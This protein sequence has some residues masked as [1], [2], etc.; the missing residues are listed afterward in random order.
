MNNP[1]IAITHD[2]NTVWRLNGYLHRKN[3]PAV[4]RLDGGE[5]W[6]LHGKLHRLDGPAFENDILRKWYVNGIN[7]LEDRHLCDTEEG[8]MILALKYG[9]PSGT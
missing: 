1:S 2:G 7:I 4:Y 3:G 8:R 5:E 9:V 6:Y